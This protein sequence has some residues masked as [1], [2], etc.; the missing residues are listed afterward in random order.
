M[1]H[2]R[3]PEIGQFR[4]AIHQ[5]TCAARKMGVDA[6]GDP[7]YDHAKSLPTLTYEGTVKLHGTNAAICLD[8]SQVHDNFMGEFWFQSRDNILKEGADN[9][10]FLRYFQDKAYPQLFTIETIDIVTAIFGEWCGG[11]IQPNVALAK[12]SKRFVIFGIQSDGVWKSKDAVSKVKFEE[13]GVYNI[14]DY[15]SFS[16]DID[17]NRPELSQNKLAELTTEV[18]KSCPVAAKHGVIGTGEGIVWKCVTPGWESPDFFFKVKGKEHSVTK[19]KQLAAV[20]VELVN[21]QR[22]FAE[23]TVTENRCRQGVSKLKEMGLK[24]DKTSVGA[25]IKWIVADIEKEESDTAKA[26]GIDIKKAGGE[27]TKAAKTWFFKNESTF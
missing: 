13:I 10:G 4:N 12:L 6:N 2:I 14:Y 19:V 27:L 20:D 25:F 18:E 17:F 16:I 7:I 8:R 26:S 1:K 15:P 11:N 21:S 9:E 22:E 23:K 3:Y 5:V 24:A